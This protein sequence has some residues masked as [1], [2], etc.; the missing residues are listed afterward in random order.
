MLYFVNLKVT[1]VYLSQL[2]IKKTVDV[3]GKLGPWVQ[4][5]EKWYCKKPYF[6]KSLIFI[7]RSNV[8]K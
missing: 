3:A 7:C 6:R 8:Q 2:F 1:G 4:I 5:P